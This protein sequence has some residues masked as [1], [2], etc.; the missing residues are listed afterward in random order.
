MELV[1]LGSG[2][3]FQEGAQVVRNPAGYALVLGRRVVLFDFGFGNLRQLWR[4]GLSAGDVSDVFL[5]HRHPDHCG[6]LV[7]LLFYFK[8]DG[9]PK[10]GELTVWGPK[11]IR[12]FVRRIQTAYAPWAE[13][14]DYKLRIRELNGNGR[15]ETRESGVEWMPVPHPTPSVA[16]RFLYKGKS[17]V[18]SGDTGYCPALADFA[19]GADLFALEC[20]VPE[21]E[22]MD[23]HLTPK[24]A[25]ATLEAS[26]CKKGLLMHLSPKSESEAR[27]LAPKGTLFARDLMRV[28]V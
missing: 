11:G 16:Y 6:D 27:R 22:R 4:A 19:A 18:Y 25:L 17:F 9:R 20:T 3:A 10:S 14:K 26:G 7:A 5:S 28:R 12:E 13:P 23:G 21:R 15:A 8:Y 2:S 1:I 24:L